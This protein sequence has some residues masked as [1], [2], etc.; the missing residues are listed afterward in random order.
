VPQRIPARHRGVALSRS[1]REQIGPIQ[2]AVIGC[3]DLKL[4]G[5][6]LPGHP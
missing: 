5:D 1:E 4:E 6:V 3:D 2:I